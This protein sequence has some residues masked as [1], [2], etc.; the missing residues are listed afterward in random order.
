[1]AKRGYTILKHALGY[2]F[3]AAGVQ[4]NVKPCTENS[5][6]CVNCAIV[7]NV[8]STVVE[9]GVRVALFLRYTW[10][11]I[12]LAEAQ[13]SLAKRA[14][15]LQNGFTEG[16]EGLFS[17]ISQARI[18]INMAETFDN[19]RKNSGA[20]AKYAAQAALDAAKNAAGNAGGAATSLADYLE[21]AFD[22][23]E[24]TPGT[25][26]TDALGNLKERNKAY[27]LGAS[28]HPYR[29]M[30]YAERQAVD[31][32]FLWENWPNLPF[33]ITHARDEPV[34]A[35]RV[36]TINV[37]VA[38]RMY[39]TNTNGN[40]VPLFGEPLF[41][42]LS[43]PLL[44]KCTM[45]GIIYSETSTQAE[46]LSRVTRAFWVTLIA[47]I[48]VF[49][50]QFYFGVPFLAIT[51]LSPLTMSFLT[52]IFLWVVYGWSYNC[53]PSVPVLMAAD[54]TAYI[55]DFM[56]PRPLCERFPG[57]VA[58]VCDSQTSIS[59]T[60]STQWKEC[61]GDPAYDELGYFYSTVYYV[62]LLFPS[63]YNYLRTV[64]PFRYYLSHF[65]TLDILEEPSVLRENCARLLMLDVAGVLCVLGLGLFLVYNV[66]APP[67]FALAKTSVR[68]SVQFVGLVNLLVLSVS[69]TE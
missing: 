20:A 55:N 7:D 29:I 66:V 32:K 42:S 51:F 54:A 65:Q 12:T 36:P 52:Y 63:A 23:T 14:V 31:W 40:Y 61:A 68:L 60:G 58:G 19:A 2:S 6:V 1:V 39:L 35:D 5:L 18:N 67:A 53:N 47:A 10:V 24:E 37:L 57:L 22:S 48:I 45:G 11:E 21:F 30:T 27:S 8:L 46:R 9:E 56:H 50:L 15:Q 41:Y 26:S 44:S 28:D 3:G 69:E 25:K 33:N 13:R 17:D 16:V 4:S 62:R 49:G 64:Q 59:F 43:Q 34:I 38:F